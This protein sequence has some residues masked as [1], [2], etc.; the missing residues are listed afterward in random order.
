MNADMKLS[1]TPCFFKNSSLYLFRN[2][3]I[4]LKMHFW[5]NNYL[6]GDS[7]IKVEPAWSISTSLSQYHFTR[8]VCLPYMQLDFSHEWLMCIMHRAC[9]PLNFRL[10]FMFDSCGQSRA[11]RRDCPPA[12]LHGQKHPDIFM[13]IITVHSCISNTAVPIHPPFKQKMGHLFIPNIT[14]SAKI[15]IS[16]HR[17]SLSNDKFI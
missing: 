12:F 15:W 10:M 1:F 6:I 16:R 5:W 17:M 9:A 14:V 2:A 7:R 4:L 8:H 13:K 11:F 3:L